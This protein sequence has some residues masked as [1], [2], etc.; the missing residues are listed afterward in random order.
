LHPPRRATQQL[1]ES[2][3]DDFIFALAASQSA[4]VL[5]IVKP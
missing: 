4:L 5:V 2:Y 1:L 3:E